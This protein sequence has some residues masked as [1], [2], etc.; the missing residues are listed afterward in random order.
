MDSAVTRSNAVNRVQLVLLLVEG[1][2]VAA[3]LVL[4]MWWLQARV[5]EQRYRVY[6]IFLAVPVRQRSPSHAM[7]RCGALA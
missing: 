5:T 6:S 3:L 2:V 7:W 4:Y 1:C